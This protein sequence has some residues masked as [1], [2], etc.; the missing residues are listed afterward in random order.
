MIVGS[1]GQGMVLPQ[2]DR[3]P[4]GSLGLTERKDGRIRRTA[5]AHRTASTAEIQ[6]V[7]V[8]SVTQRSVTSKTTTNQVPCS[9]SLPFVQSAMS[10]QSLLENGGEICCVF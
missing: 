4:G 5:V 8:N 3:A 1:S 10:S 6:A 2:D 7:V 9:K